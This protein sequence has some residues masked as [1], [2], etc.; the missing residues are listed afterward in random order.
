MLEDLHNMLKDSVP[1]VLICKEK[2][3]TEIT[4]GHSFIFEIFTED[5]NEITFD[6]LSQMARKVNA[7][8]RLF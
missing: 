6:K 8:G 5:D 1:Q 4:M 7:E 2:E 3:K